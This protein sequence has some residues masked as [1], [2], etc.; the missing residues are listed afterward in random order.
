M[1]TVHNPDATPAGN[2]AKRVWGFTKK[3][4]VAFLAGIGAGVGITLAVQHMQ[5][6]VEEEYVVV[7]DE[8]FQ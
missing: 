3:H 7:E 2:F 6:P 8:L 1:V 5:Q 4:A